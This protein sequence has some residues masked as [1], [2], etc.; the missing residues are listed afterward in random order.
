MLVLKRECRQRVV[1]TA[2][3]GEVIVVEL[4]D[5]GKKNCRIGFL[6]PPSVV[7]DREEVYLDKQRFT[8]GG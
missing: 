7:I 6:A 8:E 1:I 4:L 2:T 5:V 3:S